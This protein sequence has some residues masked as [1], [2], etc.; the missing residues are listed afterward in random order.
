MGWGKAKGRSQVDWKPVRYAAVAASDEPTA[1][2]KKYPYYR[3][4]DESGADPEYRCHPPV[5]RMLLSSVSQALPDGNSN[6]FR[7]SGFISAE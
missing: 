1:R 3:C 2:G 5:H 4:S 7:D 6:S